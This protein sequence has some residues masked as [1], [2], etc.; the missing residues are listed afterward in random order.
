MKLDDVFRR[1]TFIDM[2]CMQR[3]SWG[4]SGMYLRYIPETP[5]DTPCIQPRFTMD[6]PD[7]ESQ[8][9]DQRSPALLKG[10]SMV[11]P[12]MYLGCIRVVSS[13]SGVSPGSLIWV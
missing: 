10:V 8:Q 3:V 12:G 1:T 13:V 11:Y 5:Q 6:T 9:G 4:F 7:A 2:G